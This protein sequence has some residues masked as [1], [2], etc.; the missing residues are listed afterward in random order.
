MFEVLV[1]RV[2]VGVCR[3]RN[4]ASLGGR[5][6]GSRRSRR[7]LVW[8]GGWCLVWVWGLG[9]HG[10]GRLGIW[11]TGWLNHEASLWTITEVAAVEARC[12]AII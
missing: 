11:E 10:D 5:C 3:G 4:R 6:D 12:V 7:S 1:G 9:V 2:G 8:C